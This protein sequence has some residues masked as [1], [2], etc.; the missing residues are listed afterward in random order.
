MHVEATG[1]INLQLFWDK[2]QN[3]RVVSPSNYI[4]MWSNRE[5]GGKLRYTSSLLTLRLV[6]EQKLPEGWEAFE[7]RAS[8]EKDGG[9]YI[10]FELLTLPSDLSKTPL[11]IV[12]GPVR[13]NADTDLREFMRIDMGRPVRI[14]DLALDLDSQAMS[15]K[16]AMVALPAAAA[17][18]VLLN[19]PGFVA[20]QAAQAARVT[21][22][23]A[24][25]AG[26]SSSASFSAAATCAAAAGATAV[27]GAK[28]RR[29]KVARKYDSFNFT[30]V[31]CQ[32]N[33]YTNDTGYLPDGTPLS[34]AGNKINHPERNQPE[35]PVQA[36]SAQGSYVNDVGYLP[37]GTP[38]NMAGN[39]INH[40][41]AS[42]PTA[43]YRAD[44]GYVP[45]AGNQAT[46]PPVPSTPP[47]AAAYV[48]AV[49]AGPEVSHGISF[50]YSFQK[51]AY[52]DLEFQ[53]DVGYLADGTPMNRAGNALNHPE[54][55]TPDLHT[56]GSPLPRANF[57][58][59][60]GY[61]PDGT[62]MHAAGNAINHPERMQPDI[63]APG[64]PLPKSV[65]AAD[66]G[67]LMDGTPLSFA[68]N[69]SLKPGAPSF[70]GGSAQTANAP[71][72]F[73]S[74]STAA[75]GDRRMQPAS[76]AYSMQR[77]VYADLSFTNEAGYLPDGT[78]LNRAGNALN[79]PE[80]I[81][82]DSHAPGSPLPRA[83]FVN[84]VGYLPDGTPMNLAG[85]AVNHP[86]TIQADPHSPGSPLPKSS[87]A[88]DV[89]YLVDGTPLNAA[90]NNSI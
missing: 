74:T 71:G 55:I 61:L 83:N 20:P 79:H 34:S 65:Y 9:E 68:G 69:N 14:R 41:P 70:T 19:G 75:S 86:E 48:G 27:A 22:T 80:T 8:R 44:A 39:A 32:N 51:D 85:N 50:Q 23:V 66:V 87:Y 45:A 47:A 77:D 82:P 59:S 49:S 90:G 1:F 2:D 11:A 5:K 36:Y 29:G 21:P 58:N 24:T 81:Q 73:A 78:P 26:Q 64:S 52:A 67:Y 10:E 38:I 35:P 72:T 88:A 16:Q 12:A 42:A 76:F 33:E 15:S 4:I 30:P 6:G 17:G 13:V 7:L 89:G 84:D 28:A 43:P 56:P 46:P 40:M 53:N 18:L 3:K 54:T 63:H 37:D 31:V 25:I 62:P 57:T 60:V